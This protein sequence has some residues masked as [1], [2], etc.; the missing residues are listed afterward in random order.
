MEYWKPRNE[1]LY[2]VLTGRKC[3]A[4]EDPFGHKKQKRSKVKQETRKL[5]KEQ[6]NGNE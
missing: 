4:H 2:N 3:G 5:L 6:L 1:H